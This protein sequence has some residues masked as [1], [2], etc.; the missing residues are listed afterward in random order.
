M[1]VW[2]HM[3]LLVKWIKFCCCYTDSLTSGFSSMFGGI[4]SR[5]TVI[6][7]FYVEH[8][9]HQHQIIIWFSALQV[10]DPEK[11]KNNKHKPFCSCRKKN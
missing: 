7:L 9:A 10:F 6:I 5:R 8:G 2:R 1:H 3:V 11:K 4:N